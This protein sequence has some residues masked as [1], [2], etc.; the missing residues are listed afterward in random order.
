MCIIMP[1]RNIYLD[2]Y[3]LFSESCP[4]SKK[5]ELNK[6]ILKGFVN[7]S[8][9]IPGLERVSAVIQLPGMYL[10][11]QISYSIYLVDLKGLRDIW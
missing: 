2:L 6:V 11:I 4:L 1:Y 8:R 3:Y 9:P 10:A 5:S 7:K